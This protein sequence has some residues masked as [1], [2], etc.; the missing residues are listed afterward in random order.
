M[1][2]LVVLIT[3]LNFALLLG[4]TKKINRPA[5]RFLALALVMMVV[6]MIRI[7][8]IDTRLPLQFSLALG[9]LIYFYVLKLTRPE[10]KFSWKDLPHF[11]PALLEPFV[12]PNR[13]LPFLTF[14]SVI[15][16]L[17]FSH[18]LI[19]RFYHRQQFTGGDRY[20][21][22]L[23]WLHRLLAGLGL[24]WLLW[25]P[26]TAA[27]YFYHL[28]AQTYYLFYLSVGAMLIGIA[29]AAHLRPDGDELAVKPLL[30]AGLKQ[31]GTWLKKA[32]HQNRYY[33]DPEL[34]LSSLGEKLGL[35][36]H[37]LSRV[38][39][40]VLK[41]S[42]NDFINEYRVKDVIRKMQDPAYDN[43]T[44]LGMAYDSGFNSQSSFHRIFKELTG[45][46]PAEYKK[47]LSTYKL[48][49]GSQ[50][51]AVIS[52]HETTPDWSIEK[53]IR[54]FMLRN[55]LKIALRNLR[56]SKSF[57]ALNIVGLAAGLGVSLLIV[58]YVT[59][60]LS[61]DRY[62]VNADRI[63]RIDEDIYLNDTQYDAATT[64]KFMGPT[65]VA[66]YP[67]IEQMVRFRSPGNELVR[68]GNTHIL[69][70]HFTFADSTIFNV[71]TLPMVAGDPNTALNEPNAIVIDESAARR[72]FNST[73]VIGRTLEIGANNTPLKITGVIR[74][75]PEQ[76]QFHFSFIRPIRE[77]Y[78]FNDNGDNDWIS[79]AYY[80]Y[81]L[82]RTGTTRAEV[83]EDVDEVVKRHINPALRQFFRT[84]G[85]DLEKTGNHFRC[86]IFP[87]TDVHLHSNKSGELEA[88]SNIQFVYIFSVIAVLILLIACVNF[89]NL[90]T[91]RSAGRAREVG[92]RKVAGSTK[93]H[94][95]IQFLTESTLISLFSLVLALGI[96]VV[97]LPMFNQLAGKSLNPGV[98]F[99]GG[100]LGFLIVLALLVGC[101]AGSYP[102]FYLSS[103]QPVQVLKGKM[104]AGFKSSWLRNSLVVFQFF[105]SIGLIVST[106]VIYRQ[107][108]YIRNKEVGFNREQVLV[109][110]DTWALGRDGTTRLRNDLRTLAGVTDATVTPDLPT[111]DGQYWQ[112]GW[113]PDASLDARKAILMTT[114]RVDDH[115]VPTLGMRIVK[116]RNFDLAQFP[117]DSTAIILNEAAVAALG[118]K[119]PLKLILYNHDGDYKLLTFHVVGVVKDF[120]YN[121]MHDKIHPLIMLFN[122]FNWSNMAVRFRT[123]DVPGLVRQVEGKFHAVKQGVPFNYSFMDTDFD[124]LYHAEQQTGRIFII[125]AIFAILIACLGL[126]GLV[127]YAAEQRTKEIGI[128]KVLG[129]SVSNIV[130]LISKDFTML[131]G[132]AAL[133]AF[134]VAWWA[135]YKWL[136]TFAYR[137]E[138]SWWIFLLAGAVAL[139]IALLTVSVQTVRAALANPVK[140]LRS[141]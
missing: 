2:V 33:E 20:R 107:L 106:L 40:T 42:F 37:E 108:Q 124:N 17:Y 97:L 14:I 11:V 88:N 98:L 103:F 77:A 113:F 65:L 58:L 55:Y 60:E 135:M 59:D 13:V 118:V 16:Y 81:I 53:L 32:V 126:F 52:I 133:I 36:T 110:H 123:N 80:T 43:I 27:V 120:N 1:A 132:V 74:D 115:Y 68:K 96:A 41:K 9:P 26:L 7:L 38:L 109:I 67:K 94:L 21:F 47:E 72:Y 25:V 95:I 29:A 138:I 139:V 63:Y 104:A 56:K 99:S 140:S 86:P 50:P 35:H 45:K 64:S 76:S 31:K 24:L 48:G 54:S 141:E 116:G 134:P 84:S 46:T 89:M 69:D 15:A 34:T 4:F 51:A 10:Y 75:M 111:V 66:S 101:L 83:Q 82:A 8:G 119:D 100:F 114:L 28:A 79:N 6:W 128:R 71:F 127:T 30:P 105:I 73:D 131:V 130:S 85:A 70:H 49:A 91:A 122:T 93:G 62:N 129:A 78:N 136:G 12:L 57:T 18:Q 39:N 19:Q 61:Y 117:T 112:Q 125:F 5:N 121:S 3:G 92:I 87:L 23:R 90:S 22:E 44:L 102:A 137:T